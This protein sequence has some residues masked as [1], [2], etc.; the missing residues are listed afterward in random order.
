ML[1]LYILFFAKIVNI[2]IFL[3]GYHRLEIQFRPDAPVRH[4]F[5]CQLAQSLISFGWALDSRQSI[6]R[7]MVDNH[8]CFALMLKLWP[9]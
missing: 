8:L 5:E 6:H 3:L 7:A 2:G 9:M 1:C 4:G